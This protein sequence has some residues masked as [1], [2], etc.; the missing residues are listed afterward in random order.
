[1]IE[2]K[3]NF[4]P[5]KVPPHPGVYV[6]RDNFGTVIYVGKAK[7]LRR[8]MSSYFQPGRLNQAD[9]KLRQL[10]RSIH[11]WE[12][13][14]VRT[15]DE[16]LIL[17]SNLI[18]SYAPYYNILMRDDKRYLLLK[19][20]LHDTYPTLTLARVKKDDNAT[21]FGP[22]PHGTALKSTLEFLLSHF[23][24]RACRS[25][26]PDEET[27][28]RCLKRIVKDCSS[29][30]TGAISQADY[31]RKV[32]AMLEVLNGK[33]NTVTDNVKLKM[34]ECAAKLDYERAGRWRDV[35]NNL[36]TVF[37]QHNRSF[38]HAFIPSHSG[39][40]AM[41]ALQQALKLPMPL[42]TMK[43]FDISN[44]LG[45]LAVASMTVFVDGK[46]ARDE[47]R[48]FRIKTV[49]GAN[50]FAMM[51]EAVGRHFRRLLE[52]N[53]PLPDLLIVDGGIG[54]LNA[55]LRTLTELKC[56][57]LPV[58]GLA[59]RNEEIYVP[60]RREPLVL[61]RH[62]PGLRV[63]QAVRDEAHRFAITYHRDLR[64]KRLTESLLDDLPG[65]GEKRKLAL[66]KAFGSVRELRKADVKTIT[67][68]VPGIGEALAGEIVAALGRKNR[69]KD[70]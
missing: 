51:S 61:D 45:Q 42:R 39:P 2:L 62:H 41:Q 16:A 44:L 67:T 49:E 48:R 20:N 53:R 7:N 32:Q 26:H 5:S 70:Q 56:P 52:E 68:R 38:D 10:I 14:Q 47:Y 25:N 27:R 28:K 19:I 9:V 43:C 31:M 11:T 22:F 12:F 30:C 15:E 60:G 35:L 17:E 50:D 40:E 1:M 69:E 18:K 37:G 4:L 57:V 46:P 33:L 29:P 54:Q 66:L 55:A 34:Q 21:Y 36:E 23:G 65:I 59:E 3:E 64:Q 13:F 24:L 6:Y 8:R 63:L 58:I